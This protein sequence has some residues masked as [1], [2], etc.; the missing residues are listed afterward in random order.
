MKT[1]TPGTNSTDRT[2]RWCPHC[3]GGR[4][5]QEA[6]KHEEA[7]LIASPEP[8]AKITGDYEFISVLGAGGMGVVYKCRN[9]HLDKVVAVKTLVA[10]TFRDEDLVRFQQEAKA[11]GKFKHQNLVSILN[12]GITDEGVPFMAME[13]LE[14]KTLADVLATEKPGIVELMTIFEQCCDG[15]AYAH[16]HN[17]F[18]RD[19]KP[20]N[21]MLIGQGDQRVAKILDFGIAKIADAG[22]FAQSLTRTGAIFG[23]PPYMS[24]EQCSG[25][26]ISGQSDTYSLGCVMYEAFAGR[27]PFLGKSAIETFELHLNAA[28]EPVSNFATDIYIPPELDQL[29]ARML[30]KKPED[31][32]S[33]DS[34]RWDL[35]QILQSLVEELESEGNDRE[36]NERNEELRK[37]ATKQGFPK[38]LLPVVAIA[39]IA[40]FG[41][42]YWARMTSE[43]PRHIAKA[44]A[45]NEAAFETDQRLL[46]LDQDA[47]L[48]NVALKR[49]RDRVH[50]PEVEFQ[51]GDFTMEQAEL[52]GREAKNCVFLSLY[53]NRLVTADKLRKLRNLPLKKLHL[54]RCDIDDTG[55]KEVVD[56]FAGKLEDIMVQDC[57]N[58]SDDALA[59][60]GRCTKLRSLNFDQQP[61]LTG[62]AAREL[63]ARLPNLDSL[64]FGDAPL[65]RESDLAQLATLHLGALNLSGMQ[66]SDLTLKRI[67]KQTNIRSLTLNR[68]N[69]SEAA[70]SELVIH[71]PKLDSLCISETPISQNILRTLAKRETMRG[72]APLKAL[73]LDGLP[74]TIKSV[75]II[76]K[77]K[78]LRLLSLNDCP[79]LGIAERG[80]LRDTMRKDLMLYPLTDMRTKD[81]RKV[82]F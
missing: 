27:R 22:D 25:G 10:R 42:V 15:L 69:I 38:W 73:M 80:I 5:L 36:E 61:E 78:H 23:T 64:T 18:H 63:I 8:G 58:I 16:R 68:T 75:P 55:L 46:P 13:Y 29:I 21:I 70:L 2:V 81:Y 60:V 4:E 50:L 6:C 62:A 44:A 48:D 67:G 12:F 65:V 82:E 59:Y 52:L 32:P 41:F 11:A 26:A 33:L 79:G 1:P 34:L 53:R 35:D 72:Y 37:S 19:L 20:A 74:I 43:Q 56:S 9:I 57:R 39:L 51:E 14:G 24:P 54:S 28:A 3:S 71:L 40:L 76:Q 30:A 49:A 45:P 77:F 66:I 31:R 47:V 7:Q 17:V